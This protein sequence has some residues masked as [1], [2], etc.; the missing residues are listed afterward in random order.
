VTTTVASPLLWGLF[1]LIVVAAL[2]VDLGL[3]NRRAHEPTVREAGAW[4]AVW[5]GLAGAFGAYVVHAQGLAKG[6]E[7]AQGYLLELALSADNLFVF[8]LIF[9]YFR[10]P[11]AYQHR[12]LFWGIVGAVVTRGVFIAVGAAVI[13]RFQWILYLLGVFLV[14]AAVK[15]IVQKNESIDPARNPVLRLFRRLVRVA[16]DDSGPSFTVRRDGKLWATPLL[17]VLI[18]VEAVDVTFAVDSIPAVFGVTTDAFIVL[19]SN[20]FAVLG[21]RS[22]YFLVSGLAGK[23]AYLNYGIAAVLA[24]IGGKIVL[25]AWVRIPTLVSLAIVVGVLLVAA[26]ASLVARQR[27]SK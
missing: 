21:L 23:L 4:V 2:A 3:L 22:L 14:Y 26:L 20:V 24:F 8:L 5:V 15:L 11:R 27:L 10:I 1:A 12:V 25:G 9:S 13:H 16:E 6:L 19:T 18:V 7:F 17:A